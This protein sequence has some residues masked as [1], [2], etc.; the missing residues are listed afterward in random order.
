VVNRALT[1]GGDYLLEGA[2]QHF[3]RLYQDPPLVFQ[4]KIDKDVE[5]SPSFQ[6]K[7]LGNTLVAV[8]VS[9]TVFPE[10]LRRKRAALLRVKSP[11]TVYCVCP[12]EEYQSNPND[13]Y[14]LRENGFGLVTIDA[15]GRSHTQ[16]D[17]VPLQQIILLEECEAEIEGLPKKLRQRL[18]ESF[19]TYSRDPMAGVRDVTEVFEDVIKRAAR[20][21]R[22]K[23]W[24]T[25][26]HE[27][28]TLY[29]VLTVMERR[30]P[31]DQRAQILASAR[32]FT[33][34]YRNFNHHAPKTPKALLKRTR[35]AKHAFLEGLKQISDFQGAMGDLGLKI[36]L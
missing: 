1:H 28:Q 9:E 10:I 14:D 7:R 25:Q 8:E 12:E 36:R 11:L 2:C 26:Q 13:A 29:N 31:M 27:E 18:A 15:E 33:D 3:R 5:W 17:A 23:G 32:G 30:P 21:A 16:Y 34:R 4:T 19:Q 6:F 22:Q 24:I 35:E 20:G